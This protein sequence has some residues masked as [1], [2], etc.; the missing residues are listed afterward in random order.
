MFCT[1][2]Q[3]SSASS[4]PS[5]SRSSFAG[6]ANVIAIQVCL[7]GRV[8]CGRAVV[9]LQVGHPIA[10]IVKVTG[11]SGTVPIYI[12]LVSIGG[13]PTIV[14]IVQDAVI[15]VIAITDMALPVSMSIG[16]VRV[17]TEGTVVGVVEDAVVVIVAITDIAEFI[18]VVVCLIIRN[19]GTIIADIDNA[20]IIII[21]IAGVALP[22]SISIGL[23]RVGTEGTVVNIVRNIISIDVADPPDPVVSLH[24]PVVLRDVETT[25]RSEREPGPG[26]RPEP[27][28]EHLPLSRVRVGVD[29]D[30]L[31]GPTFGE[32][33]RLSPTEY[34]G[35]VVGHRVGLAESRDD[36]S[37][38][39]RV[40]ENLDDLTRGVHGRED[41][42]I[43]VDRDPPDARR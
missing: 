32:E 10:V 21:R 16:L 13:Q 2:G 39:A 27:C 40:L 12:S 1:S 25:I 36:L 33:Q 41:P 6:V 18:Q 20:I 22:V 9:L 7:G 14:H 42:I 19:Q 4:T 30:Y 38:R 8:S 35:L 26:V 3:L 34:L 29:M 17:G 37:R 15:V 23:V 5:P 31:S 28:H 43:A 24:R 11:V